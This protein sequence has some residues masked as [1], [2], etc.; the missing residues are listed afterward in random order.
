M[1]VSSSKLDIAVALVII[2]LLIFMVYNHRKSI[3]IDKDSSDRLGVQE[4]IEKVKIELLE[5]EEK[6]IK[7]NESPL[8]ALK[9]FD[10]EINFVVKERSKGSGAFDL[11][12]LTAGGESEYNSEVTQKII[13][14]MEYAQPQAQETKAT[15]EDFDEL[16]ESK[17]TSEKKPEE[18]PKNPNKEKK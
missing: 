2:L 18:I 7:A 6:R 16:D 8:F 3:F 5:A 9:N 12:I 15:F 14:H 11:K 4:L 1:N 13:L 10:L 17:I